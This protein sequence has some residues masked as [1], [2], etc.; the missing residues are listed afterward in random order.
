MSVSAFGEIAFTVMPKPGEL[1]GCRAGEADDAGLGGGVVG[2]ADVAVQAGVRRDVDEAPVPLL[3]HHRDRGAGHVERAGEVD[4]EHGL[5]VGVG[6]LPHD[7]VA[8]DAGVV[9]DDVEP[10]GPGERRHRRRRRPTAASETS[11]SSGITLARSVAVTSARASASM[12]ATQGRAGSAK[13]WLSARP[14]PR[15]PP[16]TMTVRPVKSKR[17][18]AHHARSTIRTTP[19]SVDLDEIT[20]LD[21]GGGAHCTDDGR[22]AEIARDDHR[23]AELA[24]HLGDDGDGTDEQRH[25]PRIRDRGDQHLARSVGSSA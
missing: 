13:N 4:V 18:T 11:S 22:D 23:V 8:Q 16:V 3:P 6:E 20:G 9:D 12:S 14:M 25:P 2:L 19:R 17:S 15:A 5:P 7:A 10:A 24:A 1:L 21:R